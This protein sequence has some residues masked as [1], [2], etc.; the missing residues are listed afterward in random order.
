MSLSPELRAKV[1]SKS[2][3]FLP[4]LFTAASVVGLSQTSKPQTPSPQ[5]LPTAPALGQYAN[6]LYGICGQRRVDEHPLHIPSIG[7]FAVRAGTVLRGEIEGRDVAIRVTPEG[8]ELFEVEGV[9][10]RNVTNAD[11]NGPLVKVASSGFSFCKRDT[12][13]CP[14]M[15]NTLDRQ[16]GQFVIFDV[17]HEFKPGS[18]VT[19]QENWEASSQTSPKHKTEFHASDPCDGAGAVVEM[20]A[21][22]TQRANDSEKRLNAAYQ[23]IF[24][25]LS[26]VD[27]VTLKGLERTWLTYR[28]ERCKLEA[29]LYV[30]GTA[31]A[32]QQACISKEDEYRTDDLY[33]AYGGG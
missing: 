11:T 25:H 20:A 33:A 21:C 13:D 6:T 15:V 12:H 24:M 5:N 4:L 30:H 2:Q 14:V 19:N 27:Q 26:A 17:A 18:F 7:C 23:K 22:E 1:R 29:A 28:D 8:I 9:T 16:P 10:V 32:M 3:G 31:S